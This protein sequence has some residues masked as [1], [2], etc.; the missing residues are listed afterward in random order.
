MDDSGL[1]HGVE[2]VEEG[3]AEVDEFV[4]GEGAV[5]SDVI[6]QRLPVDELRDDEGLRR[7]ELGVEHLGDAGVL[8]P[9]Q[10]PDLACETFSSGLVIG[11]V[12][13]EDLDG[14]RVVSAVD[15]EVDDTHA[16]RA[17]LLDEAVATQILNHH[18]SKPSRAGTVRS[19]DRLRRRRR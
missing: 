1:V 10:G 14:D 16:A 3:M 8:D 2:R 6:R 7:V 9:S 19:K 5:V 17:E 18:L 4:H 11:D 13:V 15:T 12:R